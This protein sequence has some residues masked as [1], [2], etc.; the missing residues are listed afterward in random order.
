MTGEEFGLALTV[1]A[2]LLALWIVWRFARLGPTSVLWALVHVIV[3][4]VLLR[5]VPVALTRITT[6]EIPA[7][8]YIAVFALALPALVYAFV[9][10][11]WLA[12]VALGLL[13]P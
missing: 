1:G 11:A 8:V 2:A 13:R 3:A 5:L 7:L 12:R 4:C 9:S 10:G 6:S